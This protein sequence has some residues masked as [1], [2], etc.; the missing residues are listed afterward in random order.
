MHNTNYTTKQL[1]SQAE[2]EVPTEIPTTE[3]TGKYDEWIA[4]M[5]EYEA[6]R[7]AAYDPCGIDF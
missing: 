5:E 7:Y 2:I 3:Y 6:N 4:K 1:S